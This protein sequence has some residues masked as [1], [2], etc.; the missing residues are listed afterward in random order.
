MLRFFMDIYPVTNRE[1]KRFLDA[2]KYRP[3]DAVNFLRHWSNGKIPAGLESHPVVWVSLDDARVYARWAGKRLPT[4]V[5]WQYAAQGND[6]R[7][8]P[9]GKEFDSTRCNFKVNTTTAVDRY[10]HGAGP[11]G[12]MDLVGNVWQMTAD[13]YDNISYYFQMLRGGSY[14][15]PTSSIWYIRGGPWRVNEEQLLLLVSPGFDRNATIGFRCAKD[16]R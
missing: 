5:E 16:A 13:V 8:Y 3:A 14:F 1:F 4:S 6:G 12:T 15:S 7:L 2:T 10:P 9:W 11:F